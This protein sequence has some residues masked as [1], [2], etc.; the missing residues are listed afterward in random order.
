MKCGLCALIVHVILEVQL[1]VSI[2]SIRT[3]LPYPEFAVNPGLTASKA[4]L[5]LVVSVTKVMSEAGVQEIESQCLV[6]G[7]Y[8]YRE[9]NQCTYGCLVS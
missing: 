5:G 1:D 9:L 8:L 3:F 6:T 2:L 4:A 7:Q